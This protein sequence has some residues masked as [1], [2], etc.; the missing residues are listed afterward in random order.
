V[1]EFIVGISALTRGDLNKKIPLWF[2]V[3]DLDHDGVLGVD[4]ASS[5]LNE[6][7]EHPSA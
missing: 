1:K 3:F 2:S 7:A 4:G 6:W 5:V